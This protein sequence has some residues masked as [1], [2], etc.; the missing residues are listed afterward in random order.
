MTRWGVGL[1]LWMMAAPVW[2]QT[3]FVERM[4]LAT[5]EEFL[6]RVEFAVIK[7]AIAVQAEDPRTCCYPPGIT[8][9]T[10]TP[11]QQAEAARLARQR[12]AFAAQALRAS[13]AIAQQV[14][15]AVVTNAAITATS[16]DSDIEFTVNAVWTAFGRTDLP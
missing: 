15:K 5:S 11:E 6:T 4:Q 7:A 1:G 16:T 10:A 3:T 12:I 9:D 13:R 14:A 2:A 8:H